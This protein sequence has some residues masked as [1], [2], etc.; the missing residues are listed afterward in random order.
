M[1]KLKFT[2]F[3]ISL[4]YSCVCEAQ[5]VYVTLSP[6]D[7]IKCYLNLKVIN[8]QN[9]TFPTIVVFPEELRE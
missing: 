4:F 5:C 7:C 2:V 9:T 3:I 6:S 1:L 8:P